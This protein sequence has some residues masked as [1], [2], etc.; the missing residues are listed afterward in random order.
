MLD[1]LVLIYESLRPVNLPFTVL[2][3]AI[4]LYWL[5]VI[6]GLADMDMLDVEAGGGIGDAGGDLGGAD[7]ADTGGGFF[8]PISNFLALGEVPTTVVLSILISFM[9]L[10]SLIL[11]H[12]YNEGYFWKAG[13]LLVPNFVVAALATKLLTLPLKKAV[14]K[15]NQGIMEEKSILG[16]TCSVLTS[17]VTAD[18]GQAEIATEGAPLVINVRTAGGEVLHKGEIARI[19]RENRASGIY[20]ITKATNPVTQEKVC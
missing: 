3:C 6:F 5:L 20:T 14:K 16:Q 1:F 17:E 10:G 13:A 11:N 9:W 8:R 18:F 2:I 7:A 4:V 15:M 12:Y 19:A